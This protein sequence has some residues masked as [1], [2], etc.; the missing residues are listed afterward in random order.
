MISLV[1]FWFSILVT[2]IWL[3]TIFVFYLDETKSKNTTGKTEREIKRYEYRSNKAAFS[4]FISMLGTVLA[5]AFIFASNLENDYLNSLIE[6]ILVL[7]IFLFSFICLIIRRIL[8]K[9]S[10][11]HSIHK[12][13][14]CVIVFT[15]VAALALNVL[16]YILSR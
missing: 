14:K 5:C 15:S 16:T 6:L 9:K 10:E 12:F 11:N 2:C 3:L 8:K 1:C 13:Y 4:S 7:L